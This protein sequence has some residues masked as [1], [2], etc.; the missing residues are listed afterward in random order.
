MINLFKNIHDICID[1]FNMKE[2]MG[3][4]SFILIE[5]KLF[6]IKD[7]NKF[8]GMDTEIIKTI[9]EVIK[10]TIISSEVKS[11]KYHN[12]FKQTKLFVDNNI[13]NE[14]VT[15]KIQDIIK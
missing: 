11:K 14:Q 6:F 15:N 7:L 2:I 4:L 1:N 12:N 5:N 9:A 10:Y 3:Y 8:I 13:F